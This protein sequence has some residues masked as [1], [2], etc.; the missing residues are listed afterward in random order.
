MNT[1]K[2]KICSV[3][4]RIGLQIGVLSDFVQRFS[5]VAEPK[6]CSLSTALWRL[7]EEWN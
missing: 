5:I 7:V 3:C 1:Q 6:V 2:A 4:V